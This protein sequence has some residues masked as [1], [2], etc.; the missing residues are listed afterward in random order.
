MNTQNI[1]EIVVSVAVAVIG[2]LTP[3]LA[4][5]I[6]S[7]KTAQTLV[8][9]LPTLA[10]DAVVAAQELGVTTYIEGAVKKSKAVV[11]VKSALEK[12]GFKSTDEATIKNAVE[13]AYAVA[14]QDGTLA[15]YTQKTEAQEESETLDDQIAAAQ[16]AAN[17]AAAKV[18]ELEAKK[19]TTA[20]AVAK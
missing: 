3:Y 6:K 13:S 1:A 9:V 17:E 7:N 15:Q 18:K 14:T 8:S 12:L 10:K 2:V 19:T 20:T 4:K 5:F 11:A 16:K